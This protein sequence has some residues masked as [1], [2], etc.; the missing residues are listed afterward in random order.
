MTFEQIFALGVGLVGL[1]LIYW[2]GF[3]YSFKAGRERELRELAQ[4]ELDRDPTFRMKL[5]SEQLRIIEEKRHKKA[6]EIE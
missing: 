3:D 4:M 6:Y 1:P 2:L 5:L